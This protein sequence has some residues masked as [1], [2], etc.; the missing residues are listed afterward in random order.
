[1]PTTGNDACFV[2]VVFGPAFC[3]AG[4]RDAD[5]LRFDVCR[6]WGAFL[7]FGFAAMENFRLEAAR[8]LHKL[9]I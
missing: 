8:V 9:L 7:D 4:L 1:M 2:E 6:E 3:A 5:L